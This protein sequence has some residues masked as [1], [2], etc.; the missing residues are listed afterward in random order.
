MAC[1][2]DHTLHKGLN[3]VKGKIVYQEIAKAF[4]WSVDAIS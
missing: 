3:I 4:N 1:A 2:K